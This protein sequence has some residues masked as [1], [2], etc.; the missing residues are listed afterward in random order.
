MTTPTR[1][2]FLGGIGAS[3]LGVSALGASALG[4][5]A[6]AHAAKDGNVLKTAFTGVDIPMSSETADYL[7]NSP[8]LPRGGT[9]SGAVVFAEFSDFRC[10]NCRAA[11]PAVHRIAEEIAD[12]RIIYVPFPILGQASIDMALF[13]LAAGL[14]GVYEEWHY[15]VMLWPGR[16]GPRQMPKVAEKL[17]LD[18]E[19]LR[20]ETQSDTFSKLLLESQET[21]RQLGVRATPSY[22]VFRAQGEAEGKARLARR[23]EGVRTFGDFSKAIA[24]VRAA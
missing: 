22:M 20:T 16:V 18:I 1:R 23:I 9:A 19:S 10:P 11:A 13:A 4:A 17:G 7:L 12:V 21:A 3:A 6:P 15:T 2:A 8:H 14:H 5:V 24:E